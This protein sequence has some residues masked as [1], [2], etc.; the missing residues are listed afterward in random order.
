MSRKKLAT[1]QKQES[2]SQVEERLA[3]RRETSR[4]SSQKHYYKSLTESREKAAARAKLYR[5]RKKS[6]LISS[7]LEE[8]QNA[9]RKYSKK[10]YY[11]DI[12]K[13]RLNCAERARRYRAAKK[14]R[15]Q[16]HVSP[17]SLPASA[18]NLRPAPIPTAPRKYL[19]S[20]LELAQRTTHVRVAMLGSGERAVYNPSIYHLHFLPPHLR[21][22][23]PNTVLD[24]AN[25]RSYHHVLLPQLR[26]RHPSTVLNCANLC[27]YHHF[28]L[29]HLRLRHPNTVP[30][31]ANL[32]SRLHRPAGS[33]QTTSAPRAPYPHFPPPPCFHFHPTGNQLEEKA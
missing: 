23:H 33:A 2:A 21:L 1:S 16:K 32:R 29:R 6:L 14:G 8:R 18:P 12:V 9:S 13:T 17:P 28:L 7:T 11:K 15:Q 10:H 27:S 26:L 25:L 30:D 20:S 31:C 24:S 3:K 22:R 5:A 4:L 19:I